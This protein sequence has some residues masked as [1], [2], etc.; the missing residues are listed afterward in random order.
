M[1]ALIESLVAS[2]KLRS[3][4]PTSQNTFQ[5]SDVI[6]IANEEMSLK[7]VGDIFTLRED[8]FLTSKDVAL[9]AGVDRVSIPKRAIGNTFKSLWYVDGTVRH[10]ITSAN[11]TDVASFSG[12]TGIPGKFHIEG[13]EVVLLPTPSS[14]TG[15][16]RFRY[17]A[18]PNELVETSECAKITAVSSASGTT[19]FTVDTDLS[20]SLSVGSY[21]DFVSSKSPYLLWADEVA[22]TA[23]S[24][25]QIQVATT[26]V[27]DGSGA[28]EPQINDYICA[29]GYSNIP[30][31]PVE[32]HPV[33]AQMVA[34]RMLAGLGDLEK[35]QAAKAELKEMR[36]E[37]TSLIKNRVETAPK[38]LPGQGLLRIF[39]RY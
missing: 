38:V 16:V 37:S 23:V 26:G 11:E 2:A 36:D 17:Y 31:I 9:T 5:T 7:L 29:N 10:E 15:Y 8:F 6:S 28:V 39:S 27:D 3:F 18:K 22:I 13:D 21:V 35:W 30:M 24:A 1:S 20:G 32:F 19:T 33:L 4:A 25:T 12:S 14:T 34:V